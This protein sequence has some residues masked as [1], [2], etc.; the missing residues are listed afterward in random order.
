MASEL[1]PILRQY[2]RLAAVAVLAILL[3][4]LLYLIFAGLRQTQ[5]VQEYDGTVALKQPTKADLQPVSLEKERKLIE[6]TATPPKTALLTVQQDPD[7]AN[8]CTPERRLLCVTCAKPISWKAEKCPFCETVQPAE[9]KLDLST[10]DSDGDGLTDQWEL[11]YGLNPQDP[12]DADFD[13]DKDGFTN[14]EEFE[15]KTDPTNPKSHPGYETRMSVSAI[16]GKK[17]P[18]RA[19]DKM[20]LPATTGADGKPVRHFQVTFVS[21]SEDGT[22]GSTPIRAKDGELIGKSGYRF[23]AYTELPKKQITVGANKQLRFI[24]VSTVEVE[25]VADKKRV[26][27]IFK[28]PDNPAWPGDP[29]L[30]QKATIAIDLPETAPV[31]VAPGESFAVKGEKFTVKAVDPEKKL[32]KVEKNADKK[33]FDLK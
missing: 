23:I 29:L 31:T 9:K 6:E 14:L 11:K 13:T 1:P 2:D 17:L 22:Q 18:L 3:L 4:S 25:R 27:T 5:E 24:N 33:T 10:I 7:A 28:D 12:T 19:I 20:E 16:E 15:A 26:V 8:L 32:V 30:E 21:V